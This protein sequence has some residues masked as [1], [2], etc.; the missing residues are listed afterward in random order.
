[1]IDSG[2]VAADMEELRRILVSDPTPP[3]EG[4]W[5]AARR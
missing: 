1:M 2:I 3:T 5:N 4:S